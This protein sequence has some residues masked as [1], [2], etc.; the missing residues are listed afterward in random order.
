L[1]LTHSTL[2]PFEWRRYITY[3]KD[4]GDLLCFILNQMY[5][6]ELRY[7]DATRGSDSASADGGAAPKSVEVDLDTFTEKAKAVGVHDLSSF[8][9][10]DKFAKAGYEYDTANKVIV[11]THA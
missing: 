4:E 5:Q 9:A 11:R 8:F 2:P 1:F 6:D 7:F 10:S 3:K